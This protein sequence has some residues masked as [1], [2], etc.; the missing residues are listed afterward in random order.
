MST[1][2]P[3]CLTALRRMFGLGNAKTGI[4]VEYD[5]PEQL[6]Y[7]KRDDFLSEAEAS[8]F[9]VLKTMTGEKVFICPKVSLAELLYVPMGVEWQVFQNKI[10]RKR[11]D[12][13][14]CDAETLKPIL[15][16]EL[17]DASHNRADRLERDAFVEE[18]FEA[19]GLALARVPVRQGYNT[20]ELAQVFTAA[21]EKT[22]AT[23]RTKARPIIMEGEAPICP[24]CG[25]RMVLRTAK[26]GRRAGEQFYGCPNYPRCRAMAPVEGRGR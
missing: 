8:F 18:A 22:R 13:L 19:A 14:L 20:Q 17:D 5:E 4:T 12:F 7:R 1:E 25:A 11:V 3:G 24:K 16:I 15:A 21:V 9:R 2:N 6:P 23:A 10:D 26:R